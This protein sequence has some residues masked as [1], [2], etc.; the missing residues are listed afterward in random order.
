MPH[1][2]GSPFADNLTRLCGLFNVTLADL[3]EIIGVSPV[4]LSYLRTGHRP[5]SL[6]TLQAIAALF[7]VSMDCMLDQP[8]SGLLDDPDHGGEWYLRVLEK[9][10]AAKPS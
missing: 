10:E 3:G 5:P 4:S 9:I 7:E 2:A 1:R 8:F 6:P